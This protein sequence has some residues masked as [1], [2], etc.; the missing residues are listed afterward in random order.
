MASKL[1]RF[2]LNTLI[3]HFIR[4]VFLVS[5]VACVVIIVGL[6]M[7]LVGI[8]LGTMIP[9]GEHSCPPLGKPLEEGYVMVETKLGRLVGT[10][11]TVHGVTL[12]GFLGVP[13]AQSTAGERRF[14]A[15]LPLPASEDACAVHEYLQQRPPCAQLRNG[16]TVGTEDCLHVNVW[17]PAA[18]LELHSGGVGRPVVV[19]VSGKL[20]ETGSNDDSDWP[21]L[22]AKVVSGHLG[23]HCRDCGCTANCSR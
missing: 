11:V 17:T 10:L 2:K 12:A 9:P 21:R 16:T 6:V 4:S 7:A 19:A 8:I 22:A 23:I 20:F 3:V 13:F 14:T 15:P 18:A 1:I 5:A